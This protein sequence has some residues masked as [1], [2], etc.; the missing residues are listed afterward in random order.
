M[1]VFG[2]SFDAQ[3][4]LRLVIVVVEGLWADLWS[5]G[6][7]LMRSVIFLWPSN[8]SGRPSDPSGPQVPLDYPQIAPD[9]PQTSL[10]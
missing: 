1:I 4:M 2:G 8:P 5:S 9:D 6:V 7:V 10:D 3:C